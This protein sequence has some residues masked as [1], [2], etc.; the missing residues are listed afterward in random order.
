MILV[1]NDELQTMTEKLSQQ[2]REFEAQQQLRDHTQV[3][4]LIAIKLYTQLSK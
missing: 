3:I 2:Q 4:Y 1:Y